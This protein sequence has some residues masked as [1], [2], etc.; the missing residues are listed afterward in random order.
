MFRA[1]PFMECVF[2]EKTRISSE[3]DFTLLCLQ[4]N[5]EVLLWARKFLFKNPAI[6][7]ISSKIPLVLFIETF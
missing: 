5:T 2:A 1:V 4:I 3:F 6:V 7:S